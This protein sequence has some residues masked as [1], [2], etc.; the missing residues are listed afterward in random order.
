MTLQELKA[1]GYDILVAIQNLQ[2]QLAQVNQAIV[3]Y[4]EEPKKEDKKK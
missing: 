3:N 1:R 4:K 2:N